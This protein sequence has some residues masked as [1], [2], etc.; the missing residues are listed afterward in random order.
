MSGCCAATPHSSSTTFPLQDAVDDAVDGR[1][2]ADAQCECED[3]DSREPRLFPQESDGIA[4]DDPY[5]LEPR[6]T[7][8][9]ALRL[10]DLEEPTEALE[11]S[12]PRFLAIHAARLHLRGGEF[13]MRRD[14]IIEFAVQRLPL[15]GV[16]QTGE[17]RSH[18]S[19]LTNRATI[20]VARSQF[21]VSASN[22]ARPLLVM[23]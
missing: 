5:C 12:T 14:L 17:Q 8:N 16:V 6:K 22:C 21:A 7:T 18:D 2:C 9:L 23:A 15:E 19:P 1:C 4:R 3:C 11:R 20:A 10:L 13:Q